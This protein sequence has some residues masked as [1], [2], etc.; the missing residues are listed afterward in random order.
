MHSVARAHLIVL[1]GNSVWLVLQYLSSSLNILVSFQI[2]DEV[3]CKSLHAL[4]T[5]KKAHTNDILLIS[6]HICS[7]IITKSKIVQY[8]TF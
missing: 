4:G 2:L 1:L 6:I 3:V 7:F 8:V 5:K